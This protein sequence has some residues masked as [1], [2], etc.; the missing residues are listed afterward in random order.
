[1]E[2]AGGV[3]NSGSRVG[4]ALG[5]MVTGRGRSPGVSGGQGASGQRQWSAPSALVLLQTRDNL[6]AAKAGEDLFVRKEI[7]SDRTGLGS[8]A[9]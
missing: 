7:H 5:R 1:M 2:G 6:M 8:S 3:P 4:E 9:G